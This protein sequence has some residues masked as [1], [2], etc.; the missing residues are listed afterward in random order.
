MAALW[1]PGV[2]LFPIPELREDPAFR[3]A[4]T[5]AITRLSTILARSLSKG[6][7]PDLVET[8][9]DI[10]LQNPLVV[11]GLGYQM[12]DLGDRVVGTPVRAEPVRAQQEI[13]LENRLEHRLDSGLDDPVTTVGIPSFLVP[14]DP[15][16]DH[17]LPR[18]DRP[19]AR[20]TSA[21]PDAVQEHHDP[22]WVSIRAT[23]AR[24][25]AYSP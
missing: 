11:D 6:G 12:V 21:T 14:D 22:T 25:D 18:L 1:G 9:R 23:V 7:V 2:C 5:S 3:N 20:R 8:G 4:L 16:G 13:R 19:E 24:V 17:H 10:G 15:L